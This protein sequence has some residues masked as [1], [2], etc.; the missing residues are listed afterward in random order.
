MVLPC[1]GG[2][3]RSDHGG[4]EGRMLRL[5]WPEWGR[6]KYKV[7]NSV[8]LCMQ[9]NFSLPIKSSVPVVLVRVFDVIAPLINAMCCP[10]STHV[11]AY[12]SSAT[13]AST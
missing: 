3:Q 11:S 7:S 5:A 6:E 10:F 12:E 9:E 4:G 13:T 1:K 8:V 2:M